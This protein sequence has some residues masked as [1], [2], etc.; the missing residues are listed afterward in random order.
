MGK[1]VNKVGCLHLKNDECQI[2]IVSNIVD[3]SRQTNI[4]EII[5]ECGYVQC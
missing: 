4:C 2:I 3:F 5:V 1:S